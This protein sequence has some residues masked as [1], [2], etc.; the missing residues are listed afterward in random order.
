MKSINLSDFV[1]KKLKMKYVK[2]PLSILLVLIY[3]ATNAQQLEKKPWNNRKCAVALTYDD[4]LD[5]HLDNVIPILDSLGFKGTFYAQGNSES[6]D[7][8]MEDWRKAA[9]K[10]HELGNHTLFHP[11]SKT[12]KG[13]NWV[14]N[15]YDLAKYSI[16]RIKDELI[17]ANTLLKAID[18]KTER[19][20]AY[21]CGDIEAGDSSFVDIVKEN[22]VAARGVA[23]SYNSIEKTNLNNIGA[24]VI[25]N[26][27]VNE[28]IEIAKQAIKNNTLVVFLFHG[29]GGG[30]SLNYPLDDHNKLIQFLKHNEEDIWVAPMIEIA[31]YIKESR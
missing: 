2:T 20:F 24:I 5:V 15:D 25:L 16:K 4:G 27:P 28:L 26:Q 9:N 21:T 14:S 23:P 13:R 6:L 10:G 19:T 1:L 18:G 30:H 17:L 7:V 22:F 29:V 31:K 3:M 8:R 12:P 11:C